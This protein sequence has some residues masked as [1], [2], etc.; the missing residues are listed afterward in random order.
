MDRM[1]SW[2]WAP[3]SVTRLPAMLSLAFLV[4][5]LVLLVVVLQLH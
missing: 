1:T 3:L 2:R 4:I 5:W